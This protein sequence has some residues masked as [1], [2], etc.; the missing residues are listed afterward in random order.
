[1]FNALSCTRKYNFVSVK[2]VALRVDLKTQKRDVYLIPLLRVVSP[3]KRTNITL[4][5]SEFVFSWK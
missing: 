3:P 4:G 1:M 2:N 5:A